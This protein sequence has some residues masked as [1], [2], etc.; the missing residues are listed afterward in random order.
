MKFYNNLLIKKHKNNKTIKKLKNQI[1]KIQLKKNNNE[2]FKFIKK[3]LINIAIIVL[4]SFNRY[5]I[6]KLI[7]NN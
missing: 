4:G 7:E 3:K 1:I 6:E 2:M 5:Y